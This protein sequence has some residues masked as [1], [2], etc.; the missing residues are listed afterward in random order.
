MFKPRHGGF[1]I[2]PLQRCRLVGQ[3][4]GA[5]R[6]VEQ[7]IERPPAVRGHRVVVLNLFLY[8]QIERDNSRMVGVQETA[9]LVAA[10][11]TRSKTA[12]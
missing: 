4:V 1:D 6:R 9:V 3:R 11:L 2:F 8:E 5:E 10:S 12:A 7:C